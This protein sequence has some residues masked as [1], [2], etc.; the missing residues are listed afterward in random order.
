MTRTS[1]RTESS[2]RPGGQ[3]ETANT[4]ARILQ[5]AASTR[6]CK[7]GQVHA[8]STACPRLRSLPLSSVAMYAGEAM[9]GLLG[10]LADDLRSAQTSSAEI[11]LKD[12][13]RTIAQCYE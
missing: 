12:L 2:A 9:T 7:L 13:E 6:A 8:A 3:E 11:T 4:L 10:G 5:Q 1:T